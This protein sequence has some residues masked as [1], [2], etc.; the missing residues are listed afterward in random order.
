MKVNIF[1]V[2]LF[3]SIFLSAHYSEAGQ[4][5]CKYTEQASRRYT[6]YFCEIK[7]DGT[8]LT[9]ITGS[10]KPNKTDDDVTLFVA[11]ES[12]FKHLS[13]IVCDKFKNI[14][15]FGIINSQLESIDADSFK[16]CRKLQQLKLIENKIREIPEGL[17]NNNPEL[18]LF[19]VDKNQLRTVPENLF[20]NQNKLVFL[21]LS[22]N[23]ITS[24]AP[25]VFKSLVN[26]EKLWLAE[27]NLTKM[28]AEWFEDLYNLD[29]LGLS[30]NEIND[31]PKNSFVNTRNMKMMWI[32]NNN[33]R[34]IHGDSF[35]SDGE[36]KYLSVKNNKIESIDEKL[37]DKT[38]I[39][40]LNMEGNICS[41][42]VVAAQHEMKN[43][44]RGC[45]NNYKPRQE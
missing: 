20:K 5:I 21:Y 4:G 29:R 24:L 27:N 32:D 28:H 13:S 34:T 44:F 6:G 17:L 1:K 31:I 2:T 25:R 37:F 19:R 3:C 8:S 39:S 45:F 10:H 26:L 30:Y 12:N 38:Q 14:D 40:E 15:A 36:L 18:W 7:I 35:G 22:Q 11:R 23:K 42:N 33:L 9:E 16:H 43:A 41:Q